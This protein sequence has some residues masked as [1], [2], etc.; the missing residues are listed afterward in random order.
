MN[1][2]L[3]VSRRLSL[4]RS[5]SG[6]A[7][8]VTAI[9]GVALALMIMEFTIAIV[10]GFKDGIKERLAGFDAQISIVSPPGDSTIW[11]RKTPQLQTT[12]HE[13]LPNANAG[14]AMRTP[15]LIKTDDN[16]EAVIFLSREGDS[17]FS[18]ERSNIIDGVWPDYANDTCRNDIVLSKHTAS[19]LD[20]S[21][22]DKVYTTFFINGNVK[23]RRNRIAGIYLSNFGEYDQTVAYASLPAL[24]SIEGADS[25]SG[26][27]LD[28]RGI[29]FDSIATQ[30]QHLQNALID[31]VVKK[32]I[33]TLYPVDNITRTGAL[34]FN[35]LSLLDTN[36]VVIFLLMM[37][38]AGLTL[39]S[40][41]FILILDRIPMIGTL[42]ALG[43]S[44]PQIRKIFINMAMR[45]VG[46]GMAIGNIIGIGLLVLQKNTRI[47]PLDP[48]M[49][50]LD[51][52]P[53]EI[54]I[55]SML[56][57]NIGVIVVSWLILILPARLASNI[58]PA[59]TMNY[60]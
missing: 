36:V 42:R 50:Y 25:I 6:S 29:D 38:V 3:W 10:V 35:W 57:L 21:V 32:N 31:A 20:L 43:A 34:Y 16:F 53:V 48:E 15:G 18:F 37:A 51:S 11:V 12:L 14:L 44:K 30:A 46:I 2:S 59:K 26:N 47:I 24:Q 41:L 8:V 54:N 33:E 9:A 28:I 45:L 22:G 39:I 27:R 4:R 55:W 5:A 56:A 60:Q 19:A 40:S 13:T 23:L 7:G 58:D 52:V 17:D 1:F 49:Y